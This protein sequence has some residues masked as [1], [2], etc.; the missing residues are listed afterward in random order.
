[1]SDAFAMYWGAGSRG[2]AGVD[3]PSDTK[4]AIMATRHESSHRR[5]GLSARA[6]YRSMCLVPFIGYRSHSWQAAALILINDPR[7]PEAGQSVSLRKTRGID[8]PTGGRIKVEV[9]YHNDA[10]VW[11]AI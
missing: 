10:G 1:M 8:L 3:W 9:A 2:C 11:Q 5:R 6:M 4:I 7:C